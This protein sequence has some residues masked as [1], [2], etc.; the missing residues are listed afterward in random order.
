MKLQLLNDEY[1]V[2]QFN[3]GDI[4][5]IEKYRP[6]EFYSVTK[7]NDELSIVARTGIFSSF[8]RAES[9][10]RIFRICGTLN[11]SLIGILSKISAVLAEANISIFAVSTYNTDYIMIKNE[12][13]KKAAE[14]LR[15]NDYEVS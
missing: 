10:W 13:I 11:F 4:A 12:N 15:N 9:G 7:T 1:C 6:H 3:P 5:D 14:V 2:Y 8:I